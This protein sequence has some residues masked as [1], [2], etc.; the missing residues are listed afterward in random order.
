MHI[1]KKKITPTQGCLALKKKNLLFILSKITKE[2]R[3]K[4]G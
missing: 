4:I 3:L 2:T 1:A